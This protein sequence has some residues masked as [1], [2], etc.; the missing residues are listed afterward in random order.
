MVCKFPMHP[1][2]LRN[3]WGAQSI[4]RF[5]VSRQRQ[6]I[7]GT[8]NP[9]D[10]EDEDSSTK[11]NGSGRRQIL[12]KAGETAAVMFASL[13]LLGLAG[14]C[15]H[16]GYLWHTHRKVSMAFDGW[17]EDLREYYSTRQAASNSDWIER[18]QQKLIDDIVSGRLTGRYF[19][20]FGEKGT[21]KTSMMLSALGKVE[22]FNVV[23][24]EAHAD[25]EI[26]RI[27]LG[28]ALNFEFF[29]DYLGSLFSIRGPRENS[30]IMDI[31]RAMNV[32]EQ[33]AIIRKRQTKKPLIFIINNAHLIRDDDEGRNLVELLQ[34]KAEALSGLGLA[35][36]VFNSDD[37][38]LY[39][40][41]KK[42]G[43]R[44]D[45]IAVADFTR[46]QAMQLIRS[47]RL[48][49]FGEAISDQ[50]AATVYHLV[51]G[52]A[53]HIAAVTA[54]PDMVKACHQ[55]IDKEKHWF[56]NQCGLLGEDMDDD[57]MES[58]K[59]STSAMILA[60]E[61]VRIYNQNVKDAVLGG[62]AESIIPKIP[63]WRARQI[64]TRPDYIQ[65]YDDLNLFTLDSHSRVK[66]DSM[67][68]MHAFAEI[69]SMPGFDELL[70]ETLDRVAAI[71][72]LGRTR[73][74][75]LKDL[76]LGG[77]YKVGEYQMQL[78]AAADEDEDEND[79]YML[80][81]KGDRFYWKRRVPKALLGS[82]KDN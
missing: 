2:R 61:M 78:D 52:R 65:K 6:F 66:P 24:V 31:E 71:E 57:V 81:D 46:T 55:L 80:L 1:L 39:E 45:I 47:V 75:V 8:T 10:Q 12:L 72:S 28:K 20:L 14:L 69:A 56:L 29:E 19:L 43:T 44:L 48:R 16:R 67:V 37:Y 51:G 53:Q 70:D 58:G 22:N 4:R 82:K 62:D 74:L 36:F 23:S 59:F 25:P 33:V 79:D 41:L 38:W 3:L 68:M 13:A 27:R 11:D 30:A 32:L 9:F 34:Q 54:Q 60:R 40:R 7:P 26:F 64:M 49:H 18:D 73:E 35:T 77:K 21:G 5:S 15:Y 42:L 76:V 50:T 63:L 17:D